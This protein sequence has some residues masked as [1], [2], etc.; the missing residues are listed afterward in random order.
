MIIISFIKSWPLHTCLLIILYDEMG[1]I[2]TVCC[3][4]KNRGCPEEKHPYSWAAVWTSHFIHFNLKEELIERPWWFRLG[5]WQTFSQ[6]QSRWSCHFKENYIYYLLQMT[7]WFIS[8]WK[9]EIWKSCIC[10]HELDSIPVP[11]DFLMRSVVMLINVIFKNT[12][13]N[14]IF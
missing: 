13:Y 8:K 11:K 10:H 1:S 7:Q 4:V 9:L 2:H 5:Y 12:V 6:K 14:G 3:V